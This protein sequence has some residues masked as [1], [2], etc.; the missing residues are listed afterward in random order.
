MEKITNRY[1]LINSIDD[2]FGIVFALFLFPSNIR[3]KVS[4]VLDSFL[5]FLR[6]MKKEK[7]ITCWF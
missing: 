6:N 2:D 4:G 3:T 5:S 1:A 7:L